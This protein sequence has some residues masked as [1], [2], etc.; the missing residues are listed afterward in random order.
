MQLLSYGEMI[1][2][3]ATRR[4]TG[5]ELVSACQKKMARFAALVRVVSGLLA[6]NPQQLA[7]LNAN[8]AGVDAITRLFIAR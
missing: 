7:C 6:K 2:M 8:F 3:R 5:D 1:P 4:Y